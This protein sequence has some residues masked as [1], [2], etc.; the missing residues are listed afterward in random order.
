[1]GETINLLSLSQMAQ[2]GW[3][4]SFHN[5]ILTDPS[6]NRYPSKGGDYS[7]LSVTHYKYTTS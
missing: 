6:G 5:M 7:G 1:M 4:I 2:N 3:E